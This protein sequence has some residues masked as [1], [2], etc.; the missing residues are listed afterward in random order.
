MQADR[1]DQEADVGLR[2][3]EPEHLPLRAQALGETGEVDHQR[4]VGEAQTGQIDDDVARRGQ[5]RGERAPA[6]AAR[7]PVLVSLD[8]EDR[9]L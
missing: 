4:R 9:E 7:G 5:G 3:R 8:P 6:T 1:L 2:V